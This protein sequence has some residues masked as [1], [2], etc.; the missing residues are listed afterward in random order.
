MPVLS[1]FYGILIKMKMGDK[2]VYKR[3]DLLCR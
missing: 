3:R 2:N 1:M